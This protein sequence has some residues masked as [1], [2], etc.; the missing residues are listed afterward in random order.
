MSKPR[1]YTAK[2]ER[3]ALIAHFR[4]MA[5]YWATQPDKTAQ[6][7]CDGLA[8]SILAALDGVAADLPAFDLVVRVHESDEAYHKEQGE[9][10]HQCG[11]V[12]NGDV[13][14]HD[15]YYARKKT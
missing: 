6:E 13:H 12:I 15:L 4:N 5:R 2:E 14:M 8:F 3:A 1:A 11:L 10:W 9:N 7:R